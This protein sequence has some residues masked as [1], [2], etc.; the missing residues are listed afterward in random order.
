MK[1]LLLLL[2]LLGAAWSVRAADPVAAG[3]QALADYHPK[4]ALRIFETAANQPA[5]AR[6]ARFGRGVALLAK[7]PVDAAQLAEARRIFSEL[8]DN[9]DDAAA[10]GARFF[11]ARIAQHHQPQPDEAEAARQFERLIAEHPRSPWAQAA[12][13]RLALLQLYALDRGPPPATRVARAEALLAAAREPQAESDLRCVLL[14]AIFYYQLPVARALPHLLAVERLHQTDAV[15]RADVLV[16]LGEVSRLT[17]D[18]AQAKLFYAK[19]QAEF[20]RDQRHFMVAQRL[21][22]LE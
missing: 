11:L 18:Q 4:E 3:W 16:Q 9:G 17:G 12:L 14:N 13:G 19:F 6:A 22:A 21:Q 20:P 7:Q 2:M 10:Q 8:T 5:M 15:T 1:R